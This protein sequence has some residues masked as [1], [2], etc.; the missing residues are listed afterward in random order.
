[1]T[2]DKD[3]QVIREYL[4][5]NVFKNGNIMFSD[6]R[7]DNDVDLPDIIASLYELL[8]QEVTGEPY[9]YFFHFANKI[10][11][12]VEDDVFTERR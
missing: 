1:M 6:D 3:L 10:G 9:H 7:G 11:S 12:W 4:I 2:D 8:H 5:N